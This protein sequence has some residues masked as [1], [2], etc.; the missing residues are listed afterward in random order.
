MATQGGA[1]RRANAAGIDAL[2][3]GVAVG[4]IDRIQ[5]GVIEEAGYGQHLRIRTGY[6][7]GIGF[8]PTWSQNF[9]LNIV[10]GGDTKLQPGMVFHMILLIYEPVQWGFGVSRTVAVTE[11][12][13]EVLTPGDKGPFFKE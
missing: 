4:D 9:G 2:R 8:P 5:R 10:P 3:P 7:V 13:H 11:D 12:G 6:S 1:V